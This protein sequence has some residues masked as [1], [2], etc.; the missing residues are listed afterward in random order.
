[1]LTSHLPW[2]THTHLRLVT[3]SVLVVCIF[4]TLRL[5]TTVHCCSG[6]GRFRLPWAAIVCRIYRNAC[7]CSCSHENMRFQCRHRNGAPGG[8]TLRNNS[9][10]IGRF[11]WRTEMHR[12]RWNWLMGNSPRSCRSSDSTLRLFVSS[13]RLRPPTVSRLKRLGHVTHTWPHGRPSQGLHRPAH[14]RPEAPTGT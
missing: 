4:A 7:T 9:R 3:A 12:T 14:T 10:Q 11:Q 8:G 1:M 2:Y 13:V 5:S 6:A